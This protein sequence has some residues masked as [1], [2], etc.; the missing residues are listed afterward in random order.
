MLHT[1]E[2]NILRIKVDDY[3]AELK[4]ITGLSDETD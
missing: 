3:G 4:S 2:N 1:L